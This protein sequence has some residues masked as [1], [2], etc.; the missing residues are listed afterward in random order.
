MFIECSAKLTGGEFCRWKKIKGSVRDFPNVGLIQCEDCLLVTHSQDL[1]KSV[2]YESGSMHI[3][4][5]GYGELLSSPKSDTLR[6]TIEINR[7]A[8]EFKINSILDFGC[9]N[10]QFLS[11]LGDQSACF[12]VNLAI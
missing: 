1:S 10:G 2:D 12:Q 11:A 8:Q 4:S 7:L 6:R 9:G 3:W 5:E